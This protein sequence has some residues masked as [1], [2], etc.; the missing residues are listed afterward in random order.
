MDWQRIIS[1][2]LW[3]QQISQKELSASLDC[4]IS[5]SAINHL[6]LG[7]IRTPNYDLGNKLLKRHKK[8]KK[9]QGKE[10]A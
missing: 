7:R 9:M 1:E 10:D 3:M 2:I 5:A 4:R 6:K 8:L